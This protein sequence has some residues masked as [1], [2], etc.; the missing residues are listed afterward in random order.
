METLFCVPYSV[1]WCL[2]SLPVHEAINSSI[3][4]ILP[5][6]VQKRVMEG[7]FA[8]GRAQVSESLLND[9]NPLV[10]SRLAKVRSILNEGKS[11]QLQFPAEDLGFR[12]VSCGALLHKPVD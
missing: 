4:S 11:L 1:A 12:S 8:I 5:S 7:I 3:G 6:V 9:S 2:F 10:S